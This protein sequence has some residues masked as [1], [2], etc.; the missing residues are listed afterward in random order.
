MKV[1][2][3]SITSDDT[4]HTVE[5]STGEEVAHRVTVVVE[6]CAPRTFSVFVKAHVLSG[7][8]ASLVYGDALLEELLRFEPAALHQLYS[9]VGRF[10]R[11]LPLSLPVVLADATDQAA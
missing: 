2:L 1:Q 5:L 10:R 6:E 7:I 11:G 4:R 9:L 8:D 3:V